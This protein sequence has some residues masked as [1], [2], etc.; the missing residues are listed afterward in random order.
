K[1]DLP[2]L[3]LLAA[4]NL[5]FNVSAQ[6][7]ITHFRGYLTAACV[8]HLCDPLAGFRAQG[9]RLASLPL[10]GRRATAYSGAAIIFEACT[11][12]FIGFRVTTCG[13]PLSAPRRKALFRNAAR[14]HGSVDLQRFIRRAIWGISLRNCGYRDSDSVFNIF[15][16]RQAVSW[17]LFGCLR[18]LSL[19]VSSKRCRQIYITIRQ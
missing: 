10:L 5:E 11:T 15:E 16:P 4:Y 2:H 6:C 9:H 12:S 19:I 18:T 7:H 1:Y 14:T 3:G 17:M 8:V 13:N